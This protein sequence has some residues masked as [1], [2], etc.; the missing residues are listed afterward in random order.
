MK[1]TFKILFYLKKSR[2]S[3][4]GKLPI[5][6]RLTVEGQRVEWNTQR[7]CFEEQ[8]NN[9]AGRL[10]GSNKESRA[11]NNWLE[12]V[13]AKLF[14]SQRDLLAEGKD[15]TAAS[16]KRVYNGESDPETPVHTLLQVYAYHND[17]FESLVGKEYS[18]GTL[19]K[20]KTAY[21]SVEQ[22]I[23]TKYHIEDIA[24]DKLN[25]Q[26]IAEYEYYLK[27]EKNIAH[28]TAM[29]M[30]KK[31]KKIVR[32][33]L[34]NDWLVKDPFVMYKIKLR[35]TNR[36]FLTEFEV[37]SLSNKV[38]K[39]ERLK[40]IKDLFLFSCYTG[41]SYIDLMELK[42][43]DIIVGIDREMW[44]S[45]N[46]TKTGTPSRMPLLPM[47]LEIVERYSNHPKA[48]NAGTVFPM[49]TNQKVNA[50]LKEIADVVGI[51]KELT[52]HCA[53]HT[54]ATTITLSNGVPMETVSKMLGHK[55]VRT[56][57]IYAKVVDRKIS[58][59]MNLL[60]SK[61]LLKTAD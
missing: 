58:E 13:N 18:I 55:S 43:S 52:F 25:H 53:R 11:I 49:L 4:Q 35:E 45:T 33:C 51:Q 50:Y 39:I 54:F 14:E 23:R 34:A 1:K 21:S 6:V 27:A 57:Q 42:P 22:F 2:T 29:G 36:A 12:Q 41:L 40:L 26:F 16:I 5:Y 17:Q 37:E 20:F 47:A 46:R 9:K 38:F 8:W 61:L 30:I 7:F 56:T 24:L 31:L 3:K 15:V 44:L 32:Q 48:V 59:D 19:K 10:N 28:N 60:R